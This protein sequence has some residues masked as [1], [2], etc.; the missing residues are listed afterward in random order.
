MGLAS[1]ISQMFA[2]GPVISDKATNEWV[3][4]L[5][6]L[7]CLCVVLSSQ[8]KVQMNAFGICYILDVCVFSWYL[9]PR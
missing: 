7:R 8:P 4:Y 5:L 1:V 6:Y 9:S 2:C 3:W